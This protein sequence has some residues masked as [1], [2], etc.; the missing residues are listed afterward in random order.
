MYDHLIQTTGN[1]DY[2]K[3]QCPAGAGGR[4]K[5]VAATLFQLLIFIELGLSDIPDEK[6]MHRGNT[7]M[8]YPQKR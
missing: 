3:C 6:N 1:V 2:A 5:H 7:E 4:C 8:A